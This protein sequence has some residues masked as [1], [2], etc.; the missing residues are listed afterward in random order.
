MRFLNFS[1]YLL[2]NQFA[3]HI[4][5]LQRM[6]VKS[7]GFLIF[8]RKNKILM[9][10]MLYFIAFSILFMDISEC[11]SVMKTFINSHKGGALLDMIS[12]KFD[13]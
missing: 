12:C 8:C 2:K 5:Q 6:N 3:K 1:S 9:M 4:V 11:K 10:Q 7:S 13:A